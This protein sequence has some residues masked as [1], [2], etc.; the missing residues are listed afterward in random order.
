[1]IAS[2]YL[3]DVPSLQEV[4]FLVAVL[5]AFLGFA[6]GLWFT[7][8]FWMDGTSGQATTLWNRVISGVLFILTGSVP[9]AIQAI[10]FSAVGGVLSIA[11]FVGFFGVGLIVGYFLPQ[12]FVA[13][14]VFAR[15]LSVR[16][17]A[18]AGQPTPV[19]VFAFTTK[20]GSSKAC[21]LLNQDETNLGRLFAIGIEQM[22][23]V[24]ET[25]SL[26][27]SS[28]ILDVLC[29]VPITQ[30]ARDYGKS[31]VEVVRSLAKAFP[32]QTESSLP[33]SRSFS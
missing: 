9:G 26:V 2:T 7:R 16:I 1:M 20:F 15:A 11:G 25:L 24:M 27:E 21:S 22:Q 28:L 23:S 3:S 32:D 17:V 29:G 18:G 5:L 4:D 30:V 33:W 8:V 10:A 14:D 31:P 19:E 6:I 13:T 12:R